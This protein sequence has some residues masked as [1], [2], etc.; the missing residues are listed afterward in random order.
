[1]GVNVV[2][3]D[4]TSLR[5]VM[6]RFEPLSRSICKSAF[7]QTD[8]ATDSADVEGGQQRVLPLASE[9]RRVLLIVGRPWAELLAGNPLVVLARSRVHAITLSCAVIGRYLSAAKLPPNLG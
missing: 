1:M 4:Q 2:A 9:M 5:F 7:G 8:V 6:E 3:V